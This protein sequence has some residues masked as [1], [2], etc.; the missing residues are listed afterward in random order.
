M[1]VNFII[2]SMCFLRFTSL[3]SCEL[4]Y[5][6][7]WL[8]GG[9][10]C[11]YDPKWL[12]G[13]LLLMKDDAAFWISRIS[14]ILLLESNSL[15]FLICRHVRCWSW[16][17][18]WLNLRYGIEEFGP[19]ISRFVTLFDPR[20]SSFILFFWW[21]WNSPGRADSGY[22]SIFFINSNLSSRLLVGILI[23]GTSLITSMFCMLRPEWLL[24]RR[25]DEISPDIL[26][27]SFSIAICSSKFL[28]LRTNFCWWGSRG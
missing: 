2:L 20:L 19:I 7:R 21:E 23:L 11:R 9:G 8:R 6:E 27:N 1:F 10:G 15:L 13:S 22:R 5:L 26:S 12:S 24:E 25:P 4:S 18:S 3:P 16:S 14:D 17:K 28:T